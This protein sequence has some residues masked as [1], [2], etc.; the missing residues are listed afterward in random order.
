[1][2][3]ASRERGESWARAADTH[4]QFAIE[5]SQDYGPDYA[6]LMWLAA[7]C[8]KMREEVDRLKRQLHRLEKKP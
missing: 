5:H 2:S 1:M 4:Y 8:G 7:S 6:T 3:K